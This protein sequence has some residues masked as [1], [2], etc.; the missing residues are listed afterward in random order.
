M[1]ELRK[2]SK[3]LGNKKSQNNFTSL[4]I[5][6][7]NFCNNQIKSIQSGEHMTDQLSPQDLHDLAI[8]KLQLENAQLK[9][10]NYTLELFMKYGMTKDDQ[11]TPDGKIVRA[12]PKN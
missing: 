7:H 1:A 10:H 9:Y 4:L 2:S 3:L 12:E 5:I 8:Q 11:V 6:T